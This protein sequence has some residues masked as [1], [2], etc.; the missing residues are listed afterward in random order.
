[1][2]S[3]LGVSRL[4]IA[5]LEKGVGS[6]SLVVAAMRD[7]HLRL[8]GVGRGIT[9]PEQLRARR[10]QRPWTI[11]ALAERSNLSR[12]T[13]ASI[14]AGTGSMTSLDRMLTVLAPG[15]LPAATTR[16]TRFSDPAGSSK[17][18]TR[19]TPN[20]FF[21]DIVEAFGEVSLDPCAH[22]LSPVRAARRL[23]LPECGLATSWAGNKFVYINPPFSE[24][25]RWMARAADAWEKAEAERI[26]LLVPTRT[27]TKLFQ[28]IVS[29]DANVLFLE[30]RLRFEDP[31]GG[32][33]T[34]TFSLML[35]VWGAANGAI[36]RFLELQPAVWMRPWGAATSITP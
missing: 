33:S 14:E 19:F 4:A 16:P 29:R 11:G 21:G 24:L 36:K 28:R 17:R 15:A 2:A 8:N 32:S 31:F 27:D 22:P 12:K 7:L 18:D 13:I 23:I 34:T 20:A 9:L 35:V 3:R 26:L 25:S 1:M 5:R 30:G 6:V 10:L